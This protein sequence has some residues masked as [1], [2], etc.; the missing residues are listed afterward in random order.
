MAVLYLFA[1]QSDKAF[2]LFEQAVALKRASFGNNHIQVANSLVEIGIQLFSQERFQEAMAIFQES[3]R[4]R[5]ESMPPTHPLVAMVL[6]NI[7]CCEFLL[8]NNIASLQ[9]FQEAS[10]IQ[11]DALGSTARADLDLLHAAITLC[12]F[13]Y[14]KLRLKEYE[15][16][17]AVFEQALLVSKSLFA[18][19]YIYCSYNI[20]PS[21]FLGGS[22]RF[23]NPFSQMKTIGRYE[24]PEAIWSLQTPFI[25][26]Q[27]T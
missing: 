9:A 17:Q 8:K 10:D 27:T 14:M 1:G 25:R 4:I 24:I 20:L 23:S 18:I 6:N 15:E 22:C 16:A 21:F 19:V 3:K 11:H 12:N 2:G 26:K 5:L 13:G 7:A